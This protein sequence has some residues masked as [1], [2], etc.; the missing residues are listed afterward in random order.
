MLVAAYV[1]LAIVPILVISLVSFRAYERDADMI[2]DNLMD[3]A[4]SQVAQNIAGR[5][6]TYKQLLAE[7]ATNQVVRTQAALVERESPSSANY[8]LIRQR[9]TEQFS[10]KAWMAD[11]VVGIT[12]VSESMRVITFDRVW[13][14][15]EP[16]RWNSSQFK[17]ILLDTYGT[18]RNLRIFSPFSINGAHEDT[19]SL[20]DFCYPAT[21]FLPGQIFGL[22]IVEVDSAFLIDVINI[23]DDGSLLENRV[24]PISCVTDGDGRIIA[25]PTRELIGRTLADI[26]SV[27]SGITSSKSR[28]IRGSQLQVH[29]FFQRGALS[30]FAENYRTLVISLTLGLLL[31]FSLAVFYITKKLRDKF[32]RIAFAMDEFG[33]HLAEVDLDIDKDDELLSVINDRFH[34]MTGNVNRLMSELNDKNRRLLTESDRRRQAEIKALQAQ[35]NPHFLYNALDRINWLAI[36]HEEEEISQMLSGLGRLLRYSVSNVDILV[37]LAAELE[38][39]RQYVLIQGKRFGA[40]IALVN[41]VDEETSAFPIYKMLLQPLAENCVLHGMKEEPAGFAIRLSAHSLPGKRLG[42]RIADNG[43]GMDEARLQYLRGIIAQRQSLHGDSIGVS[44][45]ANRMWLYYGDQCEISVESQLG[46]GTAFTLVIP[47]RA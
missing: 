2:E 38:W 11:H 47:Y 32:G 25:S 20:I 44:N 40:E 21:D 5:L 22:L 1:L 9:M 45:V 41:D 43:R 10:Q 31:L 30:A 26:P 7:L 19:K 15:F 13:S 36:E 16:R 18:Q 42:I 28:P 23:D 37:P 24:S 6:P 46:Q 3:Y 33:E 35:I 27:N 8:A 17:R 39:M 14:D 12:F 34:K 4:V 29:L